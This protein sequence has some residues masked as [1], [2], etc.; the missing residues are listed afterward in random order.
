MAYDDWDLLV[1]HRANSLLRQ[2][3]RIQANFLQIAL[4]TQY[5]DLHGS[6]WPPPVNVVETEESLW[7]ICAIPGVAVKDVDLR[8]DGRELIVT[9]QRPLPSCCQDGELKLWE[10]PLGRFERR[11]TVLEGRTSLAI[12]KVTLQDGLLIIELKKNS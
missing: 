5:R 3:E 12:G 8:L 4:G 1:R 7:V 10:I 9:G 11:I 6:S 2:A